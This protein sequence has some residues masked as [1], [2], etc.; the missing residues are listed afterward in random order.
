M[1]SL[2]KLF[3]LSLAFLFQEYCDTPIT[4][5]MSQPNK[6]H[7]MSEKYV[8]LLLVTIPYARKV[9]HKNLLIKIKFLHYNVSMTHICMF[10]LVYKSIIIKTS[11]MSESCYVQYLNNP[12]NNTVGS[13][14]LIYPFYAQRL[15][16]LLNW[17]WSFLTGKC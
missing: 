14:F 11:D 6:Y 13:L 15:Q 2:H 16:K 4:Q 12:Y 5:S 8:I 7:G 17:L 10:L 9:S 3:W 1:K